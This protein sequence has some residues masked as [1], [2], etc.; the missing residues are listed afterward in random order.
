MALDWKIFTQRP[1]I[2]SLPLEEQ[3]R[4]FYIA[5]EK[6]IRYRSRSGGEPEATF[7]NAFS[8]SFDGSDDYLATPQIDLGST[9][10]ISFW[11]NNTDTDSGTLFGDRNTKPSAPYALVWNPGTNKFFF[12]LGNGQ[13]GY[14]ELTVASGLLRDGN[15]H[16][17]C[18]TRTGATI[19]YYIDTVLQTN[20]TNNTLNAGA[21][22]NTTI[23]NIMANHL[24]SSNAAGKID[25]VALFDYKLTQ[26]N[27]TSI[28]NSGV[29]GDITSLNPITWYRFE[30]G[31]GTTAIDAGSGGNNGTIN[32]ATYSTDV[33]S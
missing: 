9:N 12:R 3:T 27:V 20:I 14:W 33:P 13:N 6:S 23:E 8:L 21:G 32:G 25:E 19:D 29:P 11:I 1:Y 30:E 26:A 22:A 28:Y 24:G 18:L 2:K 15:W 31:S 10:S 7:I 5:N 17:H 16:H 4:L